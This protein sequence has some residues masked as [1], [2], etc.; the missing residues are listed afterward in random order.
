MTQFKA[1]KYTI[2]YFY[3][4]VH[5]AGGIIL[6]SKIDGITIKKNYSELK[7]REEDDYVICQWQARA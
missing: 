3:Y 7:I 2:K 1:I 4:F 6:V 5:I